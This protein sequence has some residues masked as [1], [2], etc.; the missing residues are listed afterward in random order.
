MGPVTVVFNTGNAYTGLV[1]AALMNVPPPPEAVHATLAA[2]PSV[3][4]TTGGVS[5]DVTITGPAPPSMV[6][7]P[8]VPFAVTAS[9]T[10]IP[11]RPEL[12]LCTTVPASPPSLLGVTSKKRN[13]PTSM[14]VGV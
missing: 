11:T 1:T 5:L 3:D 10:E 9:D 14:P 8:V 2:L 6:A 13:L 7:V 12:L 4:V